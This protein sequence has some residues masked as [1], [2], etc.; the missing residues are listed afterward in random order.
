MENRCLLVRNQT[1]IR[2]MNIVLG[3]ISNRLDLTRQK[4]GFDQIELDR[5]QSENR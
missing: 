5:N 4:L 3:V 1:E 2:Y